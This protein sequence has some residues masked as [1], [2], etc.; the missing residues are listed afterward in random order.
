MT[1]Y[2]LANAAYVFFLLA[3]GI[4]F[5]FYWK[6]KKKTG[7]RESEKNKIYACGEDMKPEELNIPSET[8]YRNLIKILKIEKLREWHTGVLSDYLLWIFLGMAVLVFVLVI[9]W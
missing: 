6:G 7:E 2:P 4:G 9:T 3:L 1:G 5:V 8:F